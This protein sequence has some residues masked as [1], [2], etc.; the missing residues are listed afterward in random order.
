MTNGLR[1][2]ASIDKH[3]AKLIHSPI[4][5]NSSST[6]FFSGAC[7][8]S[9]RSLCPCNKEHEAI[10]EIADRTALSGSG[11]AV[12]HADHGYS[13]RGNHK[14]GNLG[15]EA[16]RGHMV[17]ELNVVPSCFHRTALLIHLFRHWLYEV[18]LSHNAQR[19][20][21]R[22]RDMMPTADQSACSSLRS[23]NKKAMLS[24]GEPS[25]AA[26]NF[27]MYRILQ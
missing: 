4:L 24:Q 14:Y 22:K 16:L 12:Q 23:A 6:Q 3:A 1:Q 21:H 11:I 25:N 20:R 8:G 13:R 19:R 9:L 18:L 10:A 26:I 2:R 7:T 27:D 15:G 5:Y 17:S